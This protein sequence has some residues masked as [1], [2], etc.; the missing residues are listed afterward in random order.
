MFK[1]HPFGMLRLDPSRDFRRRSAR[2]AGPLLR[3]PKGC[4]ARFAAKHQ[5]IAAGWEASLVPK[6]PGRC[7]VTGCPLH[8][9]LGE[10]GW[11]GQPRRRGRWS[12]PGPRCSNLPSAAAAK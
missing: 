4:T 9:L 3:N 6:A 7:R 8:R 12:E 10:R 1:S 2:A 5:K 11:P